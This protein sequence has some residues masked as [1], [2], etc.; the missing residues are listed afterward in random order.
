MYQVLTC[1][2]TEHDW[3]L[4]A[5]AG[6]V[7]F[8]ASMVAISLFDRARAAHGR[9]RLVWIALDAAVSGT[10][11]WA[12]HFIAILAYDPGTGAG[13]STRVTILSL[14]FAV[15][16]TGIGLGIALSDKRRIFA[17]LGGIVVGI[18]V[19]AM[20]YTGMMAL[21]LPAR[22][23]WS[24][25]IV[26]ASVVFGSLFG[27]LALV[28]ASGRQSFGRS[29]AATVLLT[30]AIVSHH[31]TGMGA[32]TLI[33]DPTLVAEGMLISP[34]LLSFLIAG[35]AV[36]ILGISLTVASMDRRSKGALR[37]QKM[38]LDTALENMSQGLGMYDA[39]GRILLFNE[40]YMAMTGRSDLELRGRLLVDVL[41][42][43]KAAGRWEGEPEEFFAKLVADARAGRS[44]TRT[45]QQRGRLGCH[46]RGHHG[47]GAGAGADFA[48]GAPRR[49]HQSAEPHAVPRRARARAAY[50]QAHRSARRT[51]SRSRPF[52]EDQRFAWSSR[53]RRAA[54]TGR[55]APAHMCWPR[56]YGGAARRR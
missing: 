2:T 12:T 25:D 7:C 18:G 29:A 40:R 30:V 43:Q 53:R 28:I 44:A 19:A 50:G 33:P 56:R 42:E 15:L 8:L 48:Y 45:M 37:E 22:I 4:V 38:L 16:I 24:F 49:A 35:S 13:Y 52:Q 54:G 47:M 26:I 10:G 17:A 21:E 5:L 51:V 39:E 23:A 36:V 31:F 41:R 9:A 32:V 46:L 27:A 3:R 14:V 6:A 11:I 34:T 55:R 20:H 1:L